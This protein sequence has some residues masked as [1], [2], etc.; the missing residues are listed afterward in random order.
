MKE[1]KLKVRIENGKEE[2]GNERMVER[3]AA[4]K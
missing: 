2:E 4:T 1:K 3:K